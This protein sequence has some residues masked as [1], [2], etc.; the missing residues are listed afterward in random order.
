[1]ATNDALIQP[2]SSRTRRS[3][4]FLYLWVEVRAS[5]LRVEETALTLA[6]VAPRY[7]VADSAGNGMWSL[8]ELL[9]SCLAG[10]RAAAAECQADREKLL[11][12]ADDVYQRLWGYGVV[13]T[14][15]L[16]RWALGQG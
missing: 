4:K 16:D 3:N 10:V 14:D 12:K 5:L 9:H 6:T 7:D 1:M 11:F 15:R 2:L 8:L 13:M